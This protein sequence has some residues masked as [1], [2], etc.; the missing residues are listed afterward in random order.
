[1]GGHLLSLL[2]VTHACL[3]VTYRSV[4]FKQPA[5]LWLSVLFYLCVTLSANK[6]T[7]HLT[8]LNN[9]TPTSL[10]HSTLYWTEQNFTFIALCYIFYCRCFIYFLYLFSIFTVFL[11]YILFHIYC[12]IY[13]QLLVMSAFLLCCLILLCITCYC[14]NSMSKIAYLLMSTRHIKDFDFDWSAILFACVSVVNK[15]LFG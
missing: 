6:C 14:L 11:P 10:I 2:P 7:V 3:C 5:S 12:I 13:L 15:Y 1:M 8:G 4:G 9:N